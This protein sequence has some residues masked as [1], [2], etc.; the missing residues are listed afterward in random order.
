MC[1]DAKVNPTFATRT[2]SK[3]TVTLI[4]PLKGDN[5]DIRSFRTTPSIASSLHATLQKWTAQCIRDLT[6]NIEVID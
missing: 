3:S 5:Y 6:H 1:F 2:T 4:H